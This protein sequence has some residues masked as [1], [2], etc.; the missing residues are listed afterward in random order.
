M[1]LRLL[2]IICQ[3]DVVL[4]GCWSQLSKK[5]SGFAAVWLRCKSK[6][7]SS[8][9]KPQ[10]HKL[11]CGVR[12]LGFYFNCSH[13]ISSAADRSDQ[14]CNVN[15]GG[16]LIP[17]TRQEA[18]MKKSFAPRSVS[19]SGKADDDDDGLVSVFNLTLTGDCSARRLVESANPSPM[20]VFYAT[21]VTY[22]S[23]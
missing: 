17:T 2:H 18:T 5:C 12:R 15:S 21:W 6:S 16:L 11:V 9:R 20:P 8:A 7:K 14:E 4:L 1:H 23:L 19:D 3:P 10:T 13:I 22:T